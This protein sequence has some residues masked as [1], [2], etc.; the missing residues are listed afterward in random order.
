MLI[1]TTTDD[2]GCV[3]TDTISIDSI[4]LPIVE[5]GNDTTLCDLP[6]P[7]TFSGTPSGGQWTGNGVT[8]GG[9]FT[10]LG[11]GYMLLYMSI[12]TLQRVVLMKIV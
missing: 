12:R 7:V 1:L 4:P 5:A 6:I 9:V 2:F 3:N 10:S 11:T 8:S